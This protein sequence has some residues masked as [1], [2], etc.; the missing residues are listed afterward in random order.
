MFLTGLKWKL[1][2]DAIR[3]TPKTQGVFGLWDQEELVYI[4]STWGEVAL[5][6]TLAKLLELK[7]KGLVQA[8]HFTW[9]ITITPRSWSGELLRLYFSN[10]GMLPR[11]NRPNSPLRHE[12]QTNAQFA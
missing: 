3:A 6:E 7:Q 1:D 4:G 5:P 10:H 11:Y 8:S 9:E 12:F 2:A